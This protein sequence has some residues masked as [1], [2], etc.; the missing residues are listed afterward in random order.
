MITHLYMSTFS[1]VGIGADLYFFV[2]CRKQKVGV[3]NEI[4]KKYK[5]N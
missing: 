3:K 1:Q 4:I 5:K 2:Q